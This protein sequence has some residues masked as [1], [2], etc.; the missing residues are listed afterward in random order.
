MPAASPSP[1]AP[2]GDARALVLR[3]LEAFRPPRRVNV[4]DYAG[5]HRWVINPGGGYTGRWTDD[6]APYLRGPQEA[7]TSRLYTTTCIVGPGQCGKSEVA[8]NW[9]LQSVGTDPADFLWYMQTDRVMRDEV[10]DRVDRNIEA[11]EILRDRLAPDASADTQQYK[12]FRGMSVHFMVAA[13]SNTISRRAP[14]IVVD[15][16]D[17]FDPSVAG[18]MTQLD[19]RRTTFGRESMILVLSHPDRARGLTPAGW[20]AG[21]MQVY[22]RS[23]RAKWW[24]RCPHCGA[25]SSPNPT[26]SR[27]MPL[28]YDREAGLDEIARS[29][30]LLC[31]SNGCLVEDHERRAMNI[32]ALREWGGWIHEGQ[33]IDEDGQ[34]TG[35][36][37]RSDTAGFWITGEMSTLAMGGIGA[38]ARAQVEAERAFEAAADDNAERTLRDVFCKKRGIPYTPPRRV[39]TLDAAAIAERAEQIPLGI[40]QPGVRFITAFADLQG[41]RF[42]LLFRGWGPNGESWIIGHDRIA[43]DPATSPAD[44]DTLMARLT[45]AAFPLADGSGRVMKLRGAAYDLGGSPGMTQQAYD[46]WTRWRNRR[47]IRLLGI[48]SGRAVWSVLPTKGMGTPN[49]PRLSVVTPDSQRRDRR[50][51]GGN[52]VPQG[53]FNANTFKDDL[54]GQLAAAEPGPWM[55]HLPTALLGENTESSR[56][57]IARALATPAQDLQDLARE[58]A[59]APH[60]FV[61]GLLAEDRKPSGAWEHT[62]AV[63]NEP[64][65]LM[66]GTHVVAHLHGM[67]R[68][69]WSRPPAWA[70]E[71]DRNPLVGPPATPIAATPVAALPA[72]MPAAAAAPMPPPAPAQPARRSLASRYA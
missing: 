64:L 12:R 34:V 59:K 47:A 4:A 56:A 1:P 17:A 50:V 71:W 63:R 5:A 3:S 61:E 30:R 18:I 27:V 40:V 7:L 53:Q 46:A 67:A 66:V 24:W 43:A 44:W 65:D 20:S 10:K 49:A 41:N 52:Q 14:R 58:A 19:V 68:I 9:L 51:R 60:L 26:A 13:P 22:A 16:I 28:H 8:H 72:P 32:E 33:E 57:T 31:P 29:A 37:T 11:H 25:V 62:R 38:L 15:E 69:D 48:A 23:T 70:S 45:T 2:Y 42:E 6:E 55:V 35:E 36:P 21:I 39:G 54:A